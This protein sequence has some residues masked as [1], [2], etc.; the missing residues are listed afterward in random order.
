VC[1]DQLLLNELHSK[2]SVKLESF[3]EIL[4]AACKMLET[5]SNCSFSG[6]NDVLIEESDCQ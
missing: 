4:E 3:V 1:L 6:T 2:E 5:V